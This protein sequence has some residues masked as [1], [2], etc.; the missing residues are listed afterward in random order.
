MQQVC[1]A[2]KALS[3]RGLGDIEEKS[4]PARASCG[5]TAP[6]GFGADAV[7]DGAAQQMRGPPPMA[8]GTSPAWRVEGEA[9]GSV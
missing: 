7:R 3:Y 1:Q 8:T 4:P 2:G 6:H 5:S 9:A